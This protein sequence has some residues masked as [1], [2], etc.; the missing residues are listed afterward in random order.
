[1]NVYDP[2]DPNK[3]PSSPL[4]PYSPT[5]VGPG[6]YD[7][8]GNARFE[9]AEPRARG[10]YVLLGLMVAIGVIGGLIYFNHAP[11]DPN[12]QTAQAPMTATRPAT[13][14]PGPA[15]GLANPTPAPAG[16]TH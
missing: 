4:D 11:R 14:P 10:P 9:P 12:A 7:Q 13:Q 16:G 1:M 2:N 3:S 8:Y 6:A 5:P 15:N